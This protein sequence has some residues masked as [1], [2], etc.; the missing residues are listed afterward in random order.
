MP[1]CRVPCRLG[2]LIGTCTADGRPSSCYVNP[3]DTYRRGGTGDESVCDIVS[4]SL[5]T[6][7][8]GGDAS[9]GT[10]GCQ[11]A[12]ATSTLSSEQAL[13]PEQDDVDVVD[14]VRPWPFPVELMSLYLQ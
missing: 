7:P 14:E 10:E 4:T 13:Q 1:A 9:L 12:L 2:C 11:D 5:N 3:V 8:D 6:E